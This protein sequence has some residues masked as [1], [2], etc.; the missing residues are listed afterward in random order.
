MNKDNK[1]EDMLFAGLYLAL[2]IKGGKLEMHIYM[3]MSQ[4]HV[5]YF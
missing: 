1:H 3:Y 5:Y 2:F 4:S